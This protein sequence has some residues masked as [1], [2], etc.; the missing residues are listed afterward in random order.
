MNPQSRTLEGD[1][2][3][4]RLSDSA[5]AWKSARRPQMKSEKFKKQKQQSSRKQ[6]RVQRPKKTGMALRLW[7]KGAT[8][9]ENAWP[10]RTGPA[11][12]CRCESYL[13]AGQK[14]SG[15]EGI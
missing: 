1:K 11:G 10:F 14:Y 3:G 4:L 2:F 9:R 15:A 6:E 8:V 12:G 13:K 7:F 5:A